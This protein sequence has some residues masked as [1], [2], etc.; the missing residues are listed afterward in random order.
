[1]TA[2]FALYFSKASEVIFENHCRSF[3]LL[4]KH[5]FSEEFLPTS[6]HDEGSL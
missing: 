2:V 4:F 3:L 6:S 5:Q 1:M